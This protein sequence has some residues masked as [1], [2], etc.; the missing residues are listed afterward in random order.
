MSEGVGSH[1]HNRREGDNRPVPD[2]TKLTTEASEKLE[3]RM[4]V[5]IAEENKH[6]R[7]LMLEK[8]SGVAQH[9]TLNDRR[10]QERFEAQSTATAAAFVA[11]EEAIKAALESKDKA[12]ASAFE[13]AEKAI[14]K[15]ETSI[16]K[17]ADATYVSL[18]E[19]TRSLTALM[20]R[21][22]ADVRI[23]NVEERITLLSSRLDRAEA[24]KQG[25]TESKVDNRALIGTIVGVM[26]LMIAILSYFNVSGSNETPPVSSTPVIGAPLSCEV[27]VPG[28]VCTTRK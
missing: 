9:F 15:A 7:E 10:F 13:S 5:L 17:R 1:N 8:F 6:Q 26:V 4:R 21:A 23:V 14:I 19:L 16:E 12:V 22:E 28:Q 24:A 18:A 11:A 25:V 3:V 27:A 2:P 20:P